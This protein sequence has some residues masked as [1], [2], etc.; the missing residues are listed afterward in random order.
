MS[1][2][3]LKLST[4]ELSM[5]F[6]KNSNFNHGDYIMVEQDF[7]NPNADR[8]HRHSW[9]RNEKIKQGSRF[10]LVKTENSCT[11]L[12]PLTGSPVHAHEELFLS[13]LMNSRLVEQDI[14]E[15][16]D[17]TQLSGSE[18]IERLI[19]DGHLKMSTIQAVAHAMHTEQ[20]MKSD[21]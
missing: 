17:D 5:S 4:H 12:W 3:T 7:A 20:N 14:D 21:D 13:I 15:L 1:K 19:L 18:L 9:K 10:R 2:P 6:L 16:L 8:R 11:T